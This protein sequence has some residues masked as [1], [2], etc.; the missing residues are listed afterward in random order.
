[1]PEPTIEDYRKRLELEYDIFGG[2]V[3]QSDIEDGDLMPLDEWLKQV[4]DG[5]FID[6][7][8]HGEFAFDRGNG[9]WLSSKMPIHPSDITKFKITPPQWATHVLWFNK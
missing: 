2:G 5:G 4:N 3:Y 1:M 8:G 6:Y 9:V 7:D